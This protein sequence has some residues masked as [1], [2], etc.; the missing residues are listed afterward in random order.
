LTLGLILAPLTVLADPP[1]PDDRQ[2]AP[3]NEDRSTPSKTAENKP[4][5]KPTDANIAAICVAANQTEIDTSRVALATTPNSDVK[6]FAQD[7]VDDHTSALKKANDVV[8][9]LKLIP[10]EETTARSTR[11]DATAFQGKLKGARGAELDRIYVDHEVKVHQK[12]LDTIDKTLIPNVQNS[13]VKDLLQSQRSMVSNHLDKARQLQS[14]LVAKSNS[15][16]YPT[17]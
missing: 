14:T 12:L 9:K 10:E 17:K 6:K 1:P 5:A 13:D 15:N 2:P 7:M 11:S 16:K 8:D 4:T 3:Y